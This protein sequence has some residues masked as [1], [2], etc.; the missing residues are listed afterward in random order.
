MTLRNQLMISVTAMLLMAC[1]GDTEKQVE[2]T[3][4]PVEQQATPA[5]LEKVADHLST[6]SQ[7]D[8]LQSNSIGNNTKEVEKSS[9]PAESPIVDEQSAAP[10]DEMNEELPRGRLTGIIDTGRYKQAIVNNDGQVI[11][12]K[13][14]SSWQGWQVKAIN[15]DEIVVMAGDK[16]EKL[17]LHSDFHAPRL[18]QAEVERRQAILDATQAP[19]VTEPQSEPTIPPLQL[20]EEQVQEMRSRLVS[21]GGSASAQ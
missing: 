3:Q 8:S 19:Q 7:V 11:R 15:A 10:A 12:L 6:G 2:Q 17:S 16:E 21:G 18:S 14:G 4:A 9:A 5:A 13:E 20:T 1:G